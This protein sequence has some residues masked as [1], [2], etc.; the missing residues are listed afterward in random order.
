MQVTN[1]RKQKSSI[2]LIYNELNISSYKDPRREPVI[3]ILFI[4]L[5]YRNLIFK[6]TQ[7]P[8]KTSPR[9]TLTT[10]R[11]FNTLQD[12]TC[13][14]LTCRRLVHTFVCV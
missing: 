11:G 8:R 5:I 2:L 12:F 3:F 9:I 13:A 10:M 7:K 1:V 14:L 6:L 4:V